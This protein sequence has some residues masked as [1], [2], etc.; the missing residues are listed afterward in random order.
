MRRAFISGPIQGLEHDQ[1]Y[2]EAIREICRRNGFE[3]VDPWVRERVIYREGD[4]HR[5]GEGWNFDFISRD[6]R[7][8]ER[9]DVLIAYL[10]RLSAGTCMELFYAKLLGKMTITICGIRDPSPWIIAH[11]DVILGSID[12]LDGYLKRLPKPA[13]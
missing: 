11:S 3:P 8:I 10:P 13:D 2:R 6:L 1:S 12:E 7:D 4:A 5:A 9:C